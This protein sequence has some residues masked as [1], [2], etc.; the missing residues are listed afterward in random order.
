VCS[1]CNIEIADRDAMRAHFAETMIGNHSHSVR[2]TNPTRHE[3]I[4]NELDRLAED[5][6]HQFV[7]EAWEMAD[8]GVTDEEITEAMRMVDGDFEDAWR[9]RSV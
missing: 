8:D 1:T 2:I 6:L 7:E 5:A 4:V 3:R 9:E